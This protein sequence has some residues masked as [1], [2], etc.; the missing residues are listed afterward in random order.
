[1]PR[2]PE[3]STTH[4]RSTSSR[5][6]SKKWLPAPSEPS[7]AN[8][9]FACFGVSCV[10]GSWSRSHR[11]APRLELS[12]PLPTPAG[13]AFSTRGRSG[14]SVSG[15]WSAV[16]SRR[17]AI[18]PQP[19]STPTAEGMTAS[20]VGMTEPTVAPIPTWASGIRA[21]WSSTMGRRAAADAWRMAPSSTSV[22]HDHSRSVTLSMPP[23][24]R[25]PPAV[26]KP[27]PLLTGVVHR[28]RHGSPVGSPVRAWVA[29]RIASS[30]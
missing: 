26:V 4:T 10:A 7:W 2:L 5:H 14:S 18:I 24:L 30:R 22:A 1:M 12:W 8:A 20:R 3:C 13:T 21:T 6:T 16:T 28:Q 17:A 15:S 9:V 19:M 23:M 11:S 29:S 27:V 25:S